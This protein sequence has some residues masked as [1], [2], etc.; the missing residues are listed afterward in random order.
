LHEVQLAVP[1][2]QDDDSHCNRRQPTTRV[3]VFNIDAATLARAEPSLVL[4]LALAI[5]D[6]NAERRP[7]RKRA[8]GATP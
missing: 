6:G 4:E 3:G 7:F 1:R 2:R 8:S 5:V